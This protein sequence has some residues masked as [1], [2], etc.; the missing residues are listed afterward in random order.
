[1]ARL[2]YMETV[3]R[4]SLLIL[5]THL[6]E[7]GFAP[8]SSAVWSRGRAWGGW[9][10]LSPTRWLATVTVCGRDLTLRV[11]A[12]G[13]R[14]TA[15]AAAFWDSE[16]TQLCRAAAGRPVSWNKTRQK[17][18]AAMAENG[19]LLAGSAILGGVTGLTVGVVYGTRRGVLV[20]GAVSSL[21]LGLGGHLLQE[22]DLRQKR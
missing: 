17:H 2:A 12:P 5:E 7:R 11:R 22:Q 20:G 18:E 1:M 6:R 15:S 4:L 19:L 10:G 3:E 21:V 14:L 9:L 16:W 13:Q 8:T